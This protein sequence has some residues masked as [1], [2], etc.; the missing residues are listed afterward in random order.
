MIVALGKHF[1]NHKYFAFAVF[2]ASFWLSVLGRPFECTFER[3]YYYYS[4][5]MLLL[6]VAVKNK[7]L[8]F[9]LSSPT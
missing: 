9:F 2:N 8:Y 6:M 1:G 7:H 3:A 4:K 5:F